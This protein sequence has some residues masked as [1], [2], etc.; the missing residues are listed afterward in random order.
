MICCRLAWHQSDGFST[1]V[2]ETLAA[3]YKAREAEIKILAEELQVRSD[4]RPN[5][6][7]MFR[8]NVPIACRSKV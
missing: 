5:V 8:S 6:P 1:D 4:V 2:D 7:I 3:V